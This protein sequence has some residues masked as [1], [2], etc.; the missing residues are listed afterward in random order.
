[1][2][3][4][5]E[6]GFYRAVDYRGVRSISALSAIDNA[7]A[8]SPMYYIRSINFNNG[9]AVW[10]MDREVDVA[11]G[12]IIKRFKGRNFGV[13]M[14]TCGE[15]SNILKDMIGQKSEYFNELKRIFDSE[16]VGYKAI[17]NTE[18]D[19]DF[20]YTISKDYPGLDDKLQF[21]IKYV[22]EDRIHCDVYV[23]RQILDEQS[24][25]VKLSYDDTYW[26]FDIR[27]CDI[28]C[29]I[30]PRDYNAY[31]FRPIIE[32]DKYDYW[33]EEIKREEE[34]REMKK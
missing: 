15:M 2:K 29:G 28:Y 21:H 7:E 27:K 24:Y 33:K 6:R 19:P 8:D 11:C 18:N 31:G 17:L 34:I 4:L 5:V 25:I 13:G 3:E 10:I 12:T 14:S 1:M 22:E 23:R 9:D 26:K 20:I 30:F 32:A 16:S